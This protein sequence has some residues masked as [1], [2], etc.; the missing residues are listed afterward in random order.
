VDHL[1]LYEFF[2]SI[3]GIGKSRFQKPGFSAG[4]ISFLCRYPEKWESLYAEAGLFVF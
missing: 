4:E 2:S 3:A 1:L